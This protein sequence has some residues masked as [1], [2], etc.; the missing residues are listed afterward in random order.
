[1]ALGVLGQGGHDAL[2]LRHRAE[3]PG[4][5]LSQETAQLYFWPDS[6]DEAAKTN[7]HTLVSRLRKVLAKVLPENMV[8]DYLIRDKGLVWLAHCRVDAHEFLDCVKRGLGHAEQREFWQAGNAFTCANAL[9][10]GEYAQ[11]L[12]GEDPVYHFRTTLTKALVNMALA[13]EGQLADADRL[14]PAIDIVEKALGADPLNESLWILLHRLHGRISAIQ[15]RLVLHR[16]AVL[17]RSE[18]YSEKE[19]PALVG[20][21]AEFSY[22]S[23]PS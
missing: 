20:R 18:D 16:F 13:W 1:M 6:T 7:L 3:G 12:M 2:Q 9:W 5:K 21:V 23:S 8:Q 22:S 15:A 10:K 17:L 4:L 14:Q 19:I 11:G